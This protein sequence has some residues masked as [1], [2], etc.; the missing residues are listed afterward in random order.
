MN[1]AL[2]QVATR[3]ML[4]LAGA[5]SGFVVGYLIDIARGTVEENEVGSSCGFGYSGFAVTPRSWL[6]LVPMEQGDRCNHGFLWR[7]M[8]A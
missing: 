2:A 8:R 6:S 7:L 5:F 1:S 3:R 4:Q